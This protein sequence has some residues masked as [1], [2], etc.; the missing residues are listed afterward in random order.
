[1][2]ARLFRVIDHWSD[3]FAANPI[4]ALLSFIRF[5]IAF[6]SGY[7]TIGWGLNQAQWISTSPSCG[8]G[9]STSRS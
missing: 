1:M 6:D 8:T 4:Q 2:G 9:F 3:E 7:L 5:F